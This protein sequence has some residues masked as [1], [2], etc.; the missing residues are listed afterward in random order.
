MFPPQQPCNPS[1]TAL[2]AGHSG[3]CKTPAFFSPQVF[4]NTQQSKP[5]RKSPL[6]RWANAGP[7]APPGAGLGRKQGVLASPLRVPRGYVH[8]GGG[9]HVLAAAGFP[10]RPVR[11]G[12]SRT[13]SRPLHR[14]PD[15]ST[16]RA[17]SSL[18]WA[19][20][21]PRGPR[22]SPSRYRWP[23]RTPSRCPRRPPAPRGPRRGS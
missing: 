11:T 6:P 16:P 14:H 17:G 18:C 7:G 12:T 5:K 19:P 23:A 4:H 8:P 9:G 1:L 3:L 2:A 10:K 15:P 22:S 21:S 13:P 20:R